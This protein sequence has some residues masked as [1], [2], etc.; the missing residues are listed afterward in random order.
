MSEGYPTHM[1]KHTRAMIFPRTK[2]TLINLLF[3][4]SPCSP[5]LKMG[6]AF[7]FLRLSVAFPV[8]TNFQR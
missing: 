2:M 1:H 8:S 4:G 7:P 6:A 3:P 5:F